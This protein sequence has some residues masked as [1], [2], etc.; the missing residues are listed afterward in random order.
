MSNRYKL[1]VPLNF[2]DKYGKAILA[3]LFM[4]AFTV[5]LVGYSYLRLFGKS[6]DVTEVLFRETE[7]EVIAIH[8]AVVRP[9]QTG[10]PL[11]IKLVPTSVLTVT[12]PVTISVTELDPGYVVLHGER[13]QTFTISADHA[14]VQMGFDVV[15]TVGVP[16][17]LRF[18][19]TVV[20][21]Q[22][23]PRSGVLGIRV[24]RLSVE[25]FAL[26]SAVITGVVS[27]WLFFG[28]ELVKVLLSKRR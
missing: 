3:S 4:V 6:P 22:S 19:V 5:S 27:G 23:R 1:P 28:R 13:E 21:S 9:G 2:W 7:Y 24:S 16:S 20:D 15:N 18:E 12:M 11:T 26:V 14:Q 17:T 25:Q 8:Q 10:S